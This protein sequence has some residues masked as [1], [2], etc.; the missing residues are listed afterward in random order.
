[1]ARIIGIV[2]GKGGVGKTTLG[3]NLGATLAKH[4]EKNVALVDCNVTTS[5][6]GLYL[7]M[8]YCPITLNKVLRGEHKIEEAINSHYSGLNVVPA[9]LSLNDLEGVDITK[10]RSSI[11]GLFE[12]NDY[13]LL[14][15]APG[16]GREAIAGMKACDEIVYVTHPFIPSTM[17]IVRTE[18]VAKELGLKSLGIVVNMSHKK[19]YE[20]SKDEIEELTKLPVIATIPYDTHVHKSLNLKMPLVMLHPNHRVSKEMYKVASHLTGEVY[21]MDSSFRKILKSI[22]EMFKKKEKPKEV[23]SPEDLYT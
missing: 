16:L 14:D 22:R 3:I 23:E 15:I 13:V 21:E 2:S 19:Q 4:F 11:K 20:M 10:L 5:H 9:S 18:E 8:Y 12:N 1:M 6:I 7:G 17:D